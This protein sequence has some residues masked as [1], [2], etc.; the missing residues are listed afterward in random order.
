MTVTAWVLSGLVAF[1]FL[2]AVGVILPW[3]LNIA[4]VLTPIAAL[5]L[6]LVMVGAL[7]THARRGEIKQTGIVNSVIMVIALAVAV[8]RFT[9]L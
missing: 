9:Q 6:A 5:G 7:I 3:A 2:G 4:P 1:V 8:I